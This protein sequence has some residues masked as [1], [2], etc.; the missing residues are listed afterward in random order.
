MS[1]H[2]LVLCGGEAPQE[3]YVLE[4]GEHFIGRS[5]KCAI[6]VDGNAVSRQHTKLTVRGERCTV[7]N[8]GKL[9]T[10]L[11][12]EAVEKPAL[13]KNGFTVQVQDTVFRY[14]FEDGSGMATL[15][16]APGATDEGT[17]SGSFGITA[18]PMGTVRLPTGTRPL[19]THHR[20]TT[21]AGTQGSTGPSATSGGTRS[22]TGYGAVATGTQNS[23][24]FGTMGG[25]TVAMYDGTVPLEED[26]I[27]V[28]IEREES[29]RRVRRVL[30]IV[31]VLAM[32]AVGVGVFQGQKGETGPIRPAKLER[33][34]L[35]SG[36][37]SMYFASQVTRR[38]NAADQE[39]PVVEAIATVGDVGDGWLKASIIRD[40]KPDY[41]QMDLDGLLKDALP[42]LRGGEAASLTGQRKTLY[43]KPDRIVPALMYEFTSSDSSGLFLTGHGIIWR[44]G[45]ELFAV[46][47]ACKSSEKG[48]LSDEMLDALESCEIGNRDREVQYLPPIPGTDVTEL[49]MSRLWKE[50]RELMEQ[51][52]EL[53]RQGARYPQKLVGA[54]EKAIEALHYAILSGRNV[55]EELP[56]W[57]AL[58]GEI[59]QKRVAAYRDCEF[60]IDQAR[61]LGRLRNARDVAQYGLTLFPEE[62]SWHRLRLLGVSDWIDQRLK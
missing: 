10:I 30:L 61:A 46:E 20:T 1:G 57:L 26:E 2:K 12:G 24:A 43:L 36:D 47:L 42:G 39:A 60:R 50:S 7:E 34:E 53:V 55:D 13:L 28:I 40:S 35:E 17:E 9:G 15:P 19:A 54:Q 14:E 38:L 27:Q 5:R 31:G 3:E 11:N 25:G 8:M 45:K 49:D 41:L 29:V 52:K 56:E 51:A 22:N 23:G 33:F 21:G 48:R 6:Q 58:L 59:R 44:L 18:G 16:N 62:K 4:D 37:F 32:I